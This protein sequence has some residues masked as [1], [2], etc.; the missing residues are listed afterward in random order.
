MTDA[1]QPGELDVEYD[2]E[3]DCYTGSFDVTETEPSVAVVQAVA[4]VAHRD[5]LD[6]E[7]LY[8]SVD[9]DALDAIVTDAGDSNLSVSF[10]VEEFDVTVRGDASIEVRPPQAP[11]E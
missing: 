1:N 6:L 8:R 11:L 5:P 9:T 4:E 10:D 2:P 7:P 3:R